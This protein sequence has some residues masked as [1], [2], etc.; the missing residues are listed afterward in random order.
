MHD[1][2]GQSKLFD[3]QAVGMTSAIRN[4]IQIE[5]DAVI[6][7]MAGVLPAANPRALPQQGPGSDASTLRA[8][9]MLGELPDAPRVLDLGCGPGRQ[10]LAL[11]RSILRT[12]DVDSAECA[13]AYAAAFN[14]QRGYGRSAIA[15]L[16]ALRQGA[17]GV[18]VS[19]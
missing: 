13:R 16:S 6:A 17:D 5:H 10:T 9:R 14:P 19:G 1:G 18:W 8:L 2:T 11:A 4:G 3:L 7:S 12:G 15:V